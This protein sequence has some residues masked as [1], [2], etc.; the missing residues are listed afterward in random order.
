M[1]VLL[2]SCFGP[3]R[4]MPFL[5]SWAWRA[6]RTELRALTA[7]AVTVRRRCPSH[8]YGFTSLFRKYGGRHYSYGT[9]PPISS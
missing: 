9:G 5:L 2:C 1:G 4:W 3:A 7:H 6:A 8:E